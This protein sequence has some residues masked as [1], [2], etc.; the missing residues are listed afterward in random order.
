MKTF[1][2]LPVRSFEEA[3]R[4]CAK[5]G[6]LLKAGG[7]DV[8]DRLKEGMDKPDRVIS[9][10]RVPGHDG[11]Q[12]GPPGRI[13]ALATLAKLESHADVQRLYP[14]LA[15]AAAG[16][17]TPQ[18]RNMATLGGNLAQRPRCWYFR[19]NDFHCRKKGGPECFAQHGENRF[20]AIF[21]TDV[22]CCVHASATATALL[23]YGAKLETVL[24][25][26]KRSMTLDEFFVAPKEDPPRENRLQPGEIIETIV[27]PP[28][29]NGAKSVYKKLKEKE[30]FDWPLVE[31][32]VSVAVDGGRISHA[33]VVL[34]S[35][36][37]VPHRAV[38]AEKALMGAAPNAETIARAAEASVQG[39][40]PLAQN[41]HKV[42]MAKVMVARAL[43][44]ALA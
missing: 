12:I 4:E 44:E 13:G 6:S 1:T 40:T 27:I 5:P 21:D 3:S 30:T 18:I 39:A 28:Q 24:P 17:A 7:V 20:H 26:G 41:A 14:A 25:R 34:G 10:A 19:S 33:R 37:P 29:P 9:I 11:I 35:V 15:E 31:A 22:C 38:E 42:R 16:A 43:R 36:S 8:L 2:L 23:V 32:C